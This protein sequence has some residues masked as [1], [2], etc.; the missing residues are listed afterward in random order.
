MR[1]ITP[2]QWKIPYEVST[3]PLPGC[4]TGLGG[5]AVIS[6]A[7]RSMKLPGACEANLGILRKIG[8]G[9]KAGEMVETGVIGVLLGADSVEDLGR[10]HDDEAVAKILGYRPC[11]VRSFRDWLEKSHNESAV[12]HAREQA[13]ELD[14]KSSIP[15]PSSGLTGL[16][17][18]L[19]VSARAAAQR[20][21][22][23]F[24]RIAT[25]DLD[26]TIVERAK[27]AAT[28]TYEGVK[29][30][31]P[32]VAVWAEAAVVLATAFRDG[33][34][35]AANDPL[36]CAKYAFA[37]LPK[38]ITQR[39]FRGDSACDQGEVLAWLDDEARQDGPAGKIDYAISA[40]MGAELATASRAVADATWQTFGRDDDGTLR[41]WAEL[42]YV[43]ALPPETKKAKP[44]R[45]IGLRFLKPQGELFDDGHDRKFFAVVTN[46]TERGD[47]VIEWHRQKAG[48][49]EHTRDELKNALAAARMPSQKFGANA[50]WLA[51]NA[52]AYNVA[53][54][55]R[56]A[57]PTPELRAARI[58]TLR[59][60][61]LT[62]GARLTRFSRKITLR[63]AASREW[64]ARI[65][66]LLAAFPCRIQ[67]TG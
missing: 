15:A 5:S 53:A 65:I 49:I 66:R 32:V 54:A 25:V 52:L 8:L 3:E 64:I 51:I 23:G 61:F 39:G 18:V 16:Q 30:Y 63:F 13:A 43:P 46:R 50:A 44:R 48:T 58:K 40:R 57:A 31:Q 33:H 28:R 26:A 1:R 2:L 6:Q 67:P 19:G 12:V 41:Q 14:L 29:G 59:F 21:P 4:I 10:L 55:L 17:A 9:F 24:G 37:E 27:R 47:R 36:T 45:Y 35:P 56:A 22:G 11:S 38:E 42:D 20:L 62:T 60:E 34:V 7:F